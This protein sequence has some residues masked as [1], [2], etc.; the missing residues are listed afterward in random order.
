MILCTHVPLHYHRV[1]LTLS[2][3]FL[4]LV[5]TFLILYL[6]VLQLNLPLVLPGQLCSPCS[7]MYTSPKAV[8][9][10]IT[11]KKVL[12]SFIESSTSLLQKCLPSVSDYLFIFLS[13]VS[14]Q[15]L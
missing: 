9:P 14:S 15:N 4:W 2:L 7:P 10:S 12:T 13:I 11:V 8:I 3:D 6:C 1:D 5:Y